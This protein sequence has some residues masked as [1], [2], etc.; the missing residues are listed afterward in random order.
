MKVKTQIKS[1]FSIGGSLLGGGLNP[2]GHCRVDCPPI[3][4]PPIGA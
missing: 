2:G 1:G 3:K 4:S